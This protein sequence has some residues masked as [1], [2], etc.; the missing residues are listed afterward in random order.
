MGYGNIGD[1]DF[2]YRGLKW[3]APNGEGESE[4]W[5][6]DPMVRD[7]CDISDLVQPGG[8]TILRNIETAESKYKAVKMV[9]AVGLTAGAG[10][11]GA[12]AKWFYDT[13]KSDGPWDYKSKTNK[14]RPDGKSIWEPFG[15]F[16]YGVVGA[17]AGF[18][19]GNTLQRMAGL[20]QEANDIE[21]GLQVQAG[22]HGGYASI[23]ADYAARRS[24]GTYP[25]KDE[26]ADQVLIQ[27]GIAY[28]NAEC[29]K[30]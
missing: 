9:A 18:N 24:G 19:R 28:Y 5:M 8:G 7:V 11:A 29:H 22:E 23:V 3:L 13:V 14:F 27:R 30:K 1:P 12:H 26:I 20:I 25:Y 15:N 17:A 10:A 16:H 4:S 2:G 21:K 6:V